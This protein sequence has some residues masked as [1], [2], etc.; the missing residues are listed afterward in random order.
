M[1]EG[2]VLFVSH[3]MGAIRGLC[4]SALRLDRGFLYEIGQVNTVINNYLKL[5]DNQA[6]ASTIVREKTNSPI[7]INSVS[8]QD[9]ENHIFSK[10]SIED[11]IFV[12][13]DFTVRAKVSRCYL[14]FHLHDSDLNSLIFL[15]DFEH[16]ESLLLEREPGKY[17]YIINIPAPLLVPDS[18]RISVHAVIVGEGKISEYDYGCP[19]EVVDSGS[20]RAKKG[21]EWIGKVNP[22]L[23]LEILRVED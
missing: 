2:T 10:V 22:P 6:E 12:H 5:D 17:R 9:S 15:R 8:V 1:K 14:A 23:N 13:V 3:N 19:F 4:R 11:Q 20:E 18:Y 21:F 7:Q 16:E